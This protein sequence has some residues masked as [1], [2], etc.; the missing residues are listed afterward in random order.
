MSSDQDFV[1]CA[2]C[3]QFILGTASLKIAGLLRSLCAVEAQQARGW[4]QHGRASGQ[5]E[6]FCTVTASAYKTPGRLLSLGAVHCILR[7]M[8][9]D[10]VVEQA[11]QIA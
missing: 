8:R 10:N 1:C 9:W 7:M 3:I 5:A 11:F 6:Q 2:L 4:I